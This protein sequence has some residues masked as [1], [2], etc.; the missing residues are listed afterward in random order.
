MV[1]VA[2]TSASCSEP[3]AMAMP[4]GSSEATPP[5]RVISV[6]SAASR[7]VSWP[8]RCAMPVS[9]E[10]ESATV[11]RA[12]MVG[13]SS[14]ARVRSRSTPRTCPVPVTR[15][16]PSSWLTLPPIRVRISRRSSPGC[17]VV[18]GQR[19]TRTVP[20]ATRAAARNGP[21]L[22]RSG[23]TTT[24]PPAIG[25]GATTQC[26]AAS[27]RASTPRSRSTASVMSMC[28]WLGSR[29]PTWRTSSPP[30]SRGATRRSAETNWLDAEASTSTLVARGDPPPLTVN[31]R[32]PRPSSSTVRPSARSASMMPAIGR[33]RA[34][35]SPSM[36]TG[37]SA[38]AASG[39]TNRMTVP[40]RPES[41]LVSPLSEAVPSSRVGGVMSR[42]PPGSSSM[43]TP[44]ARSP[45]IMSALSREWSG[46][47]SVVGLSASAAR[48][49]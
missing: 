16:A 40:A 15:S 36:V 21:A 13:A 11:A 48:T 24:S 2:S 7:S 44:S 23:S 41:T 1:V 34:R 43:T 12:A 14:P 47:R 4:S 31:G 22:D 49:R 26:P 5:S 39:G 17:V 19:G 20:P 32:V 30:G 9:R 37:P 46:E 33:S 6:T 27:S 3:G 8:R 45:S 28:G 42:S 18:A 25:P 38:R 29:S 35:G 10:G